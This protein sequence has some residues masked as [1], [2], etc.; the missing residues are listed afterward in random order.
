MVGIFKGVHASLIADSQVAALKLAVAAAAN[1][2]WTALIITASAMLGGGIGV[3]T[4]IIATGGLGMRAA[5]FGAVTGHAVF[6]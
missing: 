5:T 1:L 3:Y 2:V 4:N 6:A